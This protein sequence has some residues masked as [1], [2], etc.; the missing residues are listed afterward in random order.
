MSLDMMSSIMHAQFNIISQMKT[1][2]NVDILFY[3]CL[4]QLVREAYLEI[5]YE[6]LLE[7]TL[8]YMKLGSKRTMSQMETVSL[9][10]QYHQKQ[11]TEAYCR[12]NY[13]NVRIR[14]LFYDIRDGIT[15]RRTLLNEHFILYVYIKKFLYDK[16]VFESIFQMF[17]AIKISPCFYVS[18]NIIEKYD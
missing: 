15:Y 2:F 18:I 3:L 4:S 17:M 7:I 5:L 6:V 9:Q 11:N 13:K 1:E 14:I 8:P 10:H 16:V 12:I